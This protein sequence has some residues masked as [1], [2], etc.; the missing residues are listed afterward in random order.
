[1]LVGLLCQSTVCVCVP[2]KHSLVRSEK[3]SEWLMYQQVR[4]GYFALRLPCP[5]WKVRPP[6]F[7][8]VKHSETLITFCILLHISGR[9]KTD[10]G[11]ER[12][13]HLRAYLNP[14][15]KWTNY[16]LCLIKTE[17]RKVIPHLLKSDIAENR[18]KGFSN[19]ARVP[20]RIA[21]NRQ[22]P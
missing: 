8:K 20:F 16:L 9:E 14:N 21:R 1:M 12:N 15:D 2:I 19:K 4:I 22:N 11:M 10:S 13:S 7:S 5:D 17:H 18:K 6:K 3:P